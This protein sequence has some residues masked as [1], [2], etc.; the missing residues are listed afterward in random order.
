MGWTEPR[1]LAEAHA[2]IGARLAAMGAHLT[3]PIEQV[4]DRPW[5]TVLR[6]PT[7]RGALFFKASAP[8]LRHEAGVVAFLAG[9]RPE[10]V[11]APLA[12]DP[13]RGWMLMA[14]A[15]IRLRELVEAERDVSRWLDVLPLYAQLQ[16]DL[17]WA[18]AELVAL[19]AP[20]M[21]LAVLPA[22][23]E[24]LL[25]E[26]DAVDLLDALGPLDAL[27]PLETAGGDGRP[28]APIVRPPDEMRR[29]REAVPRVAAMCAELAGYGIAETIQHDDLN[30]AA[31]YARDGRYL[32]LDWGDAC[33]S[34]PFFS[35]S[36]TLEGVIGWGPDD[37]EGSV[38]TTPFRDAYLAPF[39]G[40]RPDGE[41]RAA[42]GLAIR[43]GW[44]CR[45]VN[46]HVPGIDAGPTWTRL[47]M[48]L[49]GRP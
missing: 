34:H 18:A 24:A 6:V 40:G 22:R 31:V 15:G 38:D 28:G 45:A 43:L 10:V 29:L 44:A 30:D 25:D 13:E 32:I 16:V 17:A 26:L 41:L 33:V 42:F 12:V 35:M 11:P 1:F 19:G 27:D 4:H 48:F 47:R 5:S 20:D 37:V 2:W 49:D 39:A 9:R 14:D 8:A 46:G 21:R 23:Y 36:V 7:D 3:G